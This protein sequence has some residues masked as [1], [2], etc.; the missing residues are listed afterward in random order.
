M[1]MEMSGTRLEKTSAY[2]SPGRATNVDERRTVVMA[3]N[4]F[5]SHAP[6]PIA[7]APTTFRPRG[8][9]FRRAMFDR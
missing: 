1:A 7:P 9:D 8:V 5:A 6:L 3:N 4:P 2:V